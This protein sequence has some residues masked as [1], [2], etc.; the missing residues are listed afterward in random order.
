MNEQK[1]EQLVC[2]VGCY[3]LHLY[4]ANLCDPRNREAQYTGPTGASCRT[5]ARK[6]GWLINERANHGLC[7]NCSGKKKRR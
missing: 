1:S 6:D 7:P 2:V 4:C 5:E 3:V